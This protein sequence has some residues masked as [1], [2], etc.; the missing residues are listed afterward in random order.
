MRDLLFFVGQYLRH[1]PVRAR[2]PRRVHREERLFASFSS[3]KE[4]ILSYLR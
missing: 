1:Y 2:L 4:E 3:E